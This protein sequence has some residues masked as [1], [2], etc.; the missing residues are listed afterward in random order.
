MHQD[1]IFFLFTFFVG[2]GHFECG[3]IYFTM[4]DISGG[5]YLFSKVLVKLCTLYSL[6]LEGGVTVEE[7]GIWGAPR[8]V[9]GDSRF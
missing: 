2:D 6:T 5:F 1:V 7:D 3:F 9:N 4:K 8:L